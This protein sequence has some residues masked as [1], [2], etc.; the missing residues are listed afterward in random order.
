[1]A[2]INKTRYSLLGFLDMKSMSAYEMKRMIASS[3]AYFWSE[4][5]GQLYPMLNKLSAEGCVTYKED[6]AQSGGIKKIYS[7]TAKGRKQL[8]EWLIDQ[9]INN[10]FRSE[11]LLK[12]FFGGSIGVKTVMNHLAKQYEI[13][14]CELKILQ[15][16]KKKMNAMTKDDFAH[17]CRY[18][19]VDYG[20]ELTKAELLWIK[21]TIKKIEA[22]D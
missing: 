3:T 17:N 13:T 12:L 8:R 2:R 10:S 20:V 7:I 16:F 6:I 15:D 22:R 21:K 18:L 11:F 9:R 19:T 1:M 14:A 4:S 5:D